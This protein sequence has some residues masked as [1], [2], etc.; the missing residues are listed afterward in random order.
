MVKMVNV[1]G[2]KA[3]KDCIT[4]G[5]SGLRIMRPDEFSSKMFLINHDE[6]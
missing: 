3:F 6:T 2:V 4:A 1:L 5:S